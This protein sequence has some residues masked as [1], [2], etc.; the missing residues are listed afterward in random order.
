MNESLLP[1]LNPR[2]VAII[3]ASDDPNRIG[4][5]PIHFMLR[6]GFR[7]RILPVNPNRPVVQ[8][9][10]AFESIDA[11]PEVPDLAVIAVSG[12]ATAAAVEACARRGVGVAVVIASG[13]GE[14]GEEGRR[15]QQQMVA[16]ARAAGMR[17]VGP[18]TQGV[19]N[20]GN[21]AIA[22]FSTMF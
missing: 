13:F 2:S 21:G 7:G 6:Y 12:D 3:G 22:N 15:V 9:L 1:A 14:T 10:P 17:L 4:G 20:F 19:A 11:L 5:R 16:I 8:G 18:N